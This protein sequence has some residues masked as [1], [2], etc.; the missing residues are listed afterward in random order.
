[1]NTLPT[2]YSFDQVA[3]ALAVCAGAALTTIIGSVFIINAKTDNARLLAFGLAFAAGA[4]VYVSL[5]EIFVKSVTAFASVYGDVEGYKFATIAC[6]AGMVLL[7][8]LDRLLPNPHNNLQPQTNIDDQS[9]LKRVGLMA[10]VAITA[11]NVPEGMATF[12]AT[13][14]DP[15]IGMPLALAIAVHN[16]PEGVSIAIPVYYATGSR[17]KAFLAVTL[18]ALAEPLGAIL[19]YAVLAPYLTQAVFGAVFGGIA[20]AMV[21][22][23]LDEL[24]PAAKRYSQGHETAYGLISGMAA[25]AFS[26]VLFK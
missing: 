20:G 7:I 4:M 25:L 8:L 23:A 15:V 16:I 3:I 11:H 13:L 10:A 12:F 24:L 2:L 1:M 6:F 21:F 17:A 9:R 18:S 26:L 14:D 5:V 22:L 19:G